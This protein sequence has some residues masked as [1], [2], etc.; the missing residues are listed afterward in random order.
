MEFKIFR[1]I[2]FTMIGF[3]LLGCSKSLPEVTTE[4]IAHWEEGQEFKYK[5]IAKKEDINFGINQGQPTV[6]QVVNLKIVEKTN[7]YYKIEWRVIDVLNPEGIEMDMESKKVYE[8]MLENYKIEYYTDRKGG[9][10]ELINWE[11]VLDFQIEMLRNISDLVEEEQGM[12][13]EEIES[14]M[15]NMFGGRKQIEKLYIP[16]IKLLHSYFGS[17][18]HSKGINLKTKSIPNI[19]GEKHVEV[20][21]FLTVESIDTIQKKLSLIETFVLDEATRNYMFKSFTEDIENQF[22]QKDQTPASSIPTI[23]EINDE[24]SLDINYGLGII[25]RLNY[26]RY[27]KIKSDTQNLIRNK[28]F[29]INQIE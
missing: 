18:I 3:L 1:T 26:K 17:T 4:L 7:D 19:L 16:E 28:E 9:F 23:F 13:I 27:A 22:N 12:K 20:T 29:I 2:L 6:I 21:T 11:E 10:I 15:R 24:T 5:I 14:L 25:N 8:K